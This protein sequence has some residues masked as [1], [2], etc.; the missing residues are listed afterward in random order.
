MQ[1]GTLPRK[2]RQ[3]TNRTKTKRQSPLSIPSFPSR[4]SG[5]PQ[6]HLCH[7]A[8]THQYCTKLPS[9]LGPTQTLY[10]TTP[11]VLKT[12]ASVSHGYHPGI[13]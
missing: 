1:N 11:N 8:S 9:T 7:D 6:C 3:G 5:D 10:Y 4:G 2:N 13:T 12:P